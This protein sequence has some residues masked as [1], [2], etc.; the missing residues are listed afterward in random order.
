MLTEET[1]REIKSWSPFIGA[2]AGLMT[3]SSGWIATSTRLI[4]TIR[5]LFN[6]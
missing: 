6:G 3:A 4:E 5:N 2:M 1:L